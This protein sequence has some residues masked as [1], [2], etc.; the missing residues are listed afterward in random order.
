MYR[1]LRKSSLYVPEDLK[2]DIKAGLQDELP[3]TPN[4]FNQMQKVEEKNIEEI[5]YINFLQSD[6]YCDYVESKCNPHHLSSTSSSSED[7]AKHISRSSTLP[8]LHE[9]TELIN[10]DSDITCNTTVASGLSMA[11]TKDALMATQIKRLEI[12][13]SG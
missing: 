3:L 5:T 10:Y 8:T 11:L 4:I 7:L 1:F 12:T 6:T 9:D 13:P 2:Q